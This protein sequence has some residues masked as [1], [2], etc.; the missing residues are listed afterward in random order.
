MVSLIALIR[1]DSG[2][3][4]GRHRASLSAWCLVV[5]VLVASA[6][7]STLAN[8]GIEAEFGWRD[9]ELSLSFP[10]PMQTW[11]TIPSADAVRL[12]PAV[13]VE[14]TW[15]DD[16]T[17]DCLATD[18]ARFKP[19]TTY[20]IHLAEAFATQRG[21]T[22]PAQVIEAET[23]R[24]SVNAHVMTWTDGLPSIQLSSDARITAQ[25]LI[26][27]LEVTL[28]GEPASVAPSMLRARPPRQDWEPRSRFDLLVPVQ[29]ED[30]ELIVAIRPGLQ[31]EEGD[32][33]GQQSRVLVVAYAN[34]RF[35]VRSG[36]CQ[37]ASGDHTRHVEAAAL[38]LACLPEEP[39]QLSFSSPLDSAARERFQ[40]LV[41]PGIR[42]LEWLDGPISHRYGEQQ[43]LR[44]GSAVRLVA[45][46]A[47]SRMAWTLPADLADRDGRSLGTPLAVT[48]TTDVHRPA[49]RA[50]GSR[51]VVANDRRAPVLARSFNAT[52]VDIAIETLDARRKAAALTTPASPG[53]GSRPIRSRPTS[54]SLAAG[55]WV[56]WWPG[57]RPT[58]GWNDSGLQ[59]T[60]PD[61]DLLALPSGNEVLVWANAWNGD[62]PLADVHVELLLDGPD[63]EA[64]V[65]ATAQTDGEG[66]ARLPVPE[67]EVETVSEPVLRPQWVVR[68]SRGQGRSIRHAVLPA[69]SQGEWGVPL[70]RAALVRMW[71]V[72]D[73][74]LYRA[75]DRVQYR[76]WQRQQRGNRLLAGTFEDSR[77]LRLFDKVHDK[78]ILRWSMP[79]GTDGSL[80]GDL[81]L[82]VHLTDGD[83]CIG[84]DEDDYRFPGACFFVGTY[85]AQDLWVEAESRQHGVLRD[86]DRFE[87]AV[88][89]GYYSGGPAVL[90]G[91]RISSLLTPLSPAVVYPDYAGFSFLD[92]DHGAGAMVLAGENEIALA[93]DSEG[94]AV[95]SL[96]VAFDG[97]E[98]EE[99][100]A[101]GQLQVVA[102]LRLSDREATASNAASANY[103]RHDRFVGLR[104][105]GHWLA[106]S[107]PVNLEGVVIDAAGKALPGVPIGIAVHFSDFGA[108]QPDE[109]QAPLARCQLL[110]GTTAPCDFPRR[111]N[112]RYWFIASADSAAP[113]RLSRWYWQSGSRQAL[114]EKTEL[115]M[116]QAPDIPGA[117]IRMQLVQP[118]AIGRALFVMMAGDAIVAHRVVAL[119]GG[120]QLVELATATDW[121]GDLQVLVYARDGAPSRVD[122][123]LRILSPVPWSRATV[124]LPKPPAALVPLELAFD[125]DTAAPGD[126]VALRI[127][128][129]S[130]RARQLSL[131]VLDDALM[132]LAQDL[133]EN[134]DPHGEFWLG[135]VRG[136]TFWPRMQSF[137]DWRD[138]RPWLFRL[139]WTRATASSIDSVAS[140]G[141]GH[142][143]PAAPPPPP[144]WAQQAG[145]DAG[146]LDR[147]EVTGSRLGP[148]DVFVAGPEAVKDLRPREPD[149]TA[150]DRER[151]AAA[152][153]RIRF[154]DTALWLPDL[155][156]EPGQSHSVELVLPDN[157]TRWRAIAWSSD[158]DDGFHR[159][160]A[161]MEVGLPVEVRV[162]APVRVYPGDSTRIAANLRQVGDAE[163]R[164]NHELTA[165]GAGIAQRQAATLT[166]APRG[167]ASVGMVVVPQQTGE[168]DVVA[169]VVAAAGQDGIA[170]TVE[171]VSPT[172]TA[173]RIQAG[174]LDDEPR[175]LVLPVLPEGAHRARLDLRVMRSGQALI[176]RWTADLRDYRHRCWEQILSRAVAAALAL[177]R[178]D[179]DD[180]PDAQATIDE[181][182]GNAA[183]FQGEDGGFRF[184]ARQSD[185][186]HRHAEATPQ[187]VLTAYSLHAFAA[188]AELGH[189]VDETVAVQ[190][191]RFLAN[192][193]RGKISDHPDQPIDDFA[194]VL[195]A[196]TEPSPEWIDRLWQ[197]WQGLVIPSRI[198]LAQVMTRT[199]HPLADEAYRRLVEL[200]PTR[201]PVRV[202]ENP[203][204]C[205]RWL[206]SPTRD[207]C[208]L[209]HGLSQAG[210]DADGRIRRALIAGL[211]DLYAGGIMATDTQTGATCLLALRDS[212]IDRVRE[213]IIV[214]ASLDHGPGQ[215]ITLSPDTDRGDWQRQLAGATTL[216]LDTQLPS[217]TP[218]SYVAE[219]S[220]LEDARRA[221]ASAVGFSIERRYEVLRERGW[222]AIERAPVREGD[223]LRI[224]LVVRNAAL[225][226]FVAVTDAVPGGLRPADLALGALAG[227][228]LAQVSDTGSYWFDTRRLD[229]RSPR[230]Y[231]EKLPAGEHALHYFARAGNQGDYLAA[232]AV[233]ELMYGDASHARTAA[234]RIVI[235]AP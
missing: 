121:Y 61:F 211:G 115:T 129:R 31:G 17:L 109:E 138:P 157:L 42:L 177:E 181:A 3:N 93:T 7:A 134:F 98:G 226:H 11:G 59:A 178:G 216:D 192:S 144:L 80:A 94:R 135:S 156:L 102:E 65:V 4:H 68:A 222:T 215:V 213:E 72:V 87:V 212:D 43:Q 180:W 111:D 51:L 84:A 193:V 54:Q 171:V 167:Q 221:S 29:G 70:G 120:P 37:Q 132:A 110:S 79:A 173:R 2:K 89:A 116:L 169:R 166:L 126:R 30:R 127:H 225:R 44:P 119:T 40:A 179:G 78:V 83:Y 90:S 86:G 26:D 125:A 233:V 214:Q 182:L 62:Q 198:A 130:D 207:Q 224:T 158:A 131:T 113:A 1:H 128:N 201:G 191:Q 204:D 20:R 22:L 63:G 23:E 217:T 49:L 208:A 73:R 56:R 24:P 106:D 52:P 153:L 163:T 103:S 101:F 50:S 38:A 76:L 219:L 12:E 13:P 152:R 21:G 235:G 99:P 117:A 150:V 34:E 142:E 205:S 10:E 16:L 32:L 123:G 184:F 165:E 223:W 5:L 199:Q 197:R 227:L 14:C 100:P 190:A 206:S 96:P 187:M 91:G 122:D 71:G 60:A 133:H 28:D 145:G 112:G 148:E 48:I 74:P 147:I 57:G 196:M 46:E 162:Q 53:T 210:V 170:A 168:L 15:P 81:V 108:D 35:R 172:L 85:Q 67:N 36:F 33:R 195:S 176:E 174:W 124:T 6:S 161:T 9:R 234:T 183:V 92:G 164:A 66:L 146:T 175:R 185:L 229:P 155:H 143:G 118:A 105:D 159:A 39:L 104:M 203:R 151:L 209:I 77:E 230:F 55:G 189:R 136:E 41:P 188:L 140:E 75:G 137:G 200:A 107:G 69:W 18:E 220:Y 95:L 154:A 25:A 64:S 194:F 141:A 19:A 58:R 202:L 45:T 8:D 149:G 27:V 186:D 232:P 114:P 88:T 47:A 231:A 228:D 82:P 160:E 97:D 139:P 218:A